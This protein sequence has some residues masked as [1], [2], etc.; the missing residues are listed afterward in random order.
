MM[1]TWAIAWIDSRRGGMQGGA[2]LL[3]IAGD[4]AI[5]YFIAKAFGAQF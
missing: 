3:S 1:L 2:Y 5:A 4:V